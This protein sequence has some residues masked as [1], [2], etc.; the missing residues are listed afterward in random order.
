MTKEEAIE[1]M[2]G[3]VKITH[4]HFTPDEWMTMQGNRI[5]L[6]DGCSCWEHEFWS[7]RKGFGWNDGYSIFSKK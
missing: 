6:E 3:G 5:L 7:D 2:K 4:R 1:E